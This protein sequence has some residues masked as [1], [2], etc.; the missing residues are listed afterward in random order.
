MIFIIKDDSTNTTYEIPIEDIIEIYTTATGKKKIK[1]NH[2]FL[3][4]NKWPC[5]KIVN[6]EYKNLSMMAKSYI[7]SG[8][9]H[10][11]KNSITWDGGC[12]ES[13]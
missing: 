12:Y 9:T 11:I 2:R 5:H 4:D 6:I 3:T 10:I 13:D 1:F 7:V 8:E